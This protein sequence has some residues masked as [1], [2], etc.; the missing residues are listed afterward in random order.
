MSAYMGSTLGQVGQETEILN[1]V[2]HSSMSKSSG[3]LSGKLFI[4]RLSVL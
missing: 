3:G 2:G 1:L 4:G